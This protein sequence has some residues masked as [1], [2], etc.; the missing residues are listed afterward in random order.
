MPIHRFDSASDL[1]D[2]GFFLFRSKTLRD[3]VAKVSVTPVEVLPTGHL[4]VDVY[5]MARCFVAGARMPDPI[6]CAAV[7]SMGLR[8]DD[9]GLT[10]CV[11]ANTEWTRAQ[12]AQLVRWVSAVAAAKSSSPLELGPGHLDPSSSK[13]SL[14]EGAYT[15]ISDIP[16]ERLRWRFAIIQAFNL[17][18]AR[19]LELIDTTS[20][21]AGSLG[22][23]LR[24]V[25]HLVFADSRSRV[26]DAALEATFVNAWSGIQLSLS[27]ALAFQALD[28]GVRDPSISNCIFMQ[29]YR[30]IGH[31]TGRIFR[32]RQDDKQRIMTVRFEGEEGIDWGGLSKDS[33]ERALTDVFSS[34]LD[35]FIPCPNAATP[36]RPNS[37][38]FVPNPAFK[39]PR[40]LPLYEFIGKLAGGSWRH[41]MQL[42]FSLPGFV[43]QGLVGG[44]PTW[45][46]L[47]DIDEAFCARLTR[48]LQTKGAS[49]AAEGLVFT[50]PAS[51]GS[52]VE[53]VPGGASVR[54][55]A[56]NYREYYDLSLSCR[57]HEFDRAVA[58]M[59]RGLVSVVPDRVIRMVNASELEFY[60]CGS[61]FVDISVLQAKTELYGYLRIDR[62][63]RW[64]WEV[65]EGLTDEERS[66]FI[67]FV[68]G[69]SRLPRGSKWPHPFR[70]SKRSGGDDVLPVSHTCFF[71]LELPTYSSKEVMRARIL[72][73]VN[74]GLDAYLIA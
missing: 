7:L 63:I 36:G 34:N 23:L 61:V 52:L 71:Q 50:V 59:R 17:R 57:L 67:R 27:N 14:E 10:A 48:L 69:N 26:I 46:D 1:R 13:P 55:D 11:L 8:V 51:D 42:P 16:A 20:Q 35:L 66:K 24:L 15:A 49:A 12:D 22:E 2:S 43:W 21:E 5:D 56:S 4:L 73:A 19:C 39:S 38:R 18:I 65:M 3:P 37:D 53:L 44:T 25:N 64:F 9:K 31:R 30:Q 54:V 28:C 45:E 60:V 70:I 6:L 72:A 32:C 68:S 29:I 74:F 58:A 40:L 62:T 47:Q 33:F 41:K